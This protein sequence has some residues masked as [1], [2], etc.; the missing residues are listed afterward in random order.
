MGILF[1]TKTIFDFSAIS[2]TILSIRYALYNT[3]LL[4]KTIEESSVMLL[5][6]KEK[7]VLPGKNPI[8]SSLEKN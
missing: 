1:P 5:S 2:I 7:S 3:T 6:L 4:I 8:F